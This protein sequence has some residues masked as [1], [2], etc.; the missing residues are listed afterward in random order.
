MRGP[1][2]SYPAIGVAETW[3]RGYESLMNWCD[4]IRNEIQPKHG[5]R[6]TF[7]AEV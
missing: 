3:S 6:I 7:K 5:K 2:R 4:V 1:L